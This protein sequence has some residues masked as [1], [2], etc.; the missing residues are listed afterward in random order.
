MRWVIAYCVVAAM[1]QPAFAADNLIRLYGRV[2][3]GFIR[4]EVY[5]I[6]DLLEHGSEA[7]MKAARDLSLDLIICDVHVDGESGLELC[8]TLRTVEGNEDVP[9]LFVSSGQSPDI[10]R[11]KHDAG[12]TYY[13]R[14][15][16]DPDVLVELVG[17]SKMNSN[18]MLT[19]I[20]SIGTGTARTEITF[21]GRKECEAR[22]LESLFNVLRHFPR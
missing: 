4:A 21:R 5:T 11:R 17:K 13:L 18:G 14:K 8:R 12:G 15:P 7:A 10:I 9:V 19:W 2:E 22:R 1:A 6:P 3:K 16:F 20:S